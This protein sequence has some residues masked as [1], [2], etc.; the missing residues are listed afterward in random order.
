MKRIIKITIT[1]ALS[2][3]ISFSLFSQEKNN[4]NTAKSAPIK[5]EF[6]GFVN[7]ISD[8]VTLDPMLSAVISENESADK[9]M[10][11]K[12]KAE[13]M[14]QKVEFLK[15]FSPS[16]D[17]KT[18][19]NMDPV[20]ITGIEANVNQGTP[21]DNSVAVNKNGIAISVV[22]SNVKYYTVF[23]N[24]F[25][26]T[27]T[28]SLSSFFAPLTTGGPLLS[29][30]LCD[31]KVV[32]DLHKD[33]FILFA[34]TCDGDP[35]KSQI[36]VAFSKTNNPANGWWLYTY[37]MIDLPGT[38]GSNR[39]FDY[40]KI[41]V[42]NHDVF[43]TGNLFDGSIQNGTSFAE[44]VLFQINKLQG[45]NGIT[46]GA[47]GGLIHSSIDGSPLTLVP[48]KCEFG[49]SNTYDG[50]M[51]MMST[52]R[53]NGFG[54]SNLINI[55]EISDSVTANP[56]PSITFSQ[57]ALPAAY[58]FA[59]DAIQSGSSV[60]LDVG[61]M[62]GMDGYSLYEYSHFVF[63]C[64]AGSGFAGIN[65]SIFKR[66]TNGSWS[67][68]KNRI[69]KTSGV[70]YAFPA[71]SS[72]GLNEWDK[73]SS[74]IVFNSSSSSTFPGI[75]AVFVDG[76]ATTTSAIVNVKSGI[77][78]AS[79]A[80]SSNV[81][82]QQG[83]ILYVNHR[84]GDYSGLW[85]DYSTTF[86]SFIGFGMFGANNFNGDAFSN[87]LYKIKS[88]QFPL[89]TKNIEVEKT[90]VIYPNPITDRYTLKFTATSTKPIEINIVDMTGKIVTTIMKGHSAVGENVFSFNKNGLANG[91]YLLQIA[92][93]NTIIHNEKITVNA[94]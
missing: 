3:G 34:Q 5:G 29:T 87:W 84:W 26:N 46:T 76:N 8:D 2:L 6:L 24:P 64:D 91:T 48:L 45:Y 30:N 63:H 58:D 44:S 83:N 41:A 13:K 94:Q 52:N 22:N 14:K 53:P 89:E 65:Y 33:R 43:I 36:L 50:K 39:W 35:A 74:M 31:P 88:G 62:R 28:S 77:S 16:L 18:R 55:Y 51:V 69:I 9:E 15:T 79:I 40:P 47:P 82:D 23:G 10:V 90:S 60:R 59:T 4:I 75:K 66:N 70:D 68:A 67:L 42:S 12:I 86:P 20:N 56:A 92:Q 37:K 19:G 38:V 71:I 1:L 80:P 85:R 32:Y 72:C 21:S 61:D 7:P 57:V 49:P 78:P 93:E 54:L 17:K 73:Q 11:E 81:E 25:E 27:F